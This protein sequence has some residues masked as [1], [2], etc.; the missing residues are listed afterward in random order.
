MISV[1]STCF[2]GDLSGGGTPGPIPN[3][4]VKPASTDGSLWFLHA[5]VG[6]RQR[7]RAIFA[8]SL[9]GRSALIDLIAETRPFF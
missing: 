4:A 7:N 5:R 3:P 2:V 9:L 6:H 1:Y 8:L